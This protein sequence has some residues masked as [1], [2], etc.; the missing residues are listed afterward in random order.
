MARPLARRL[1]RPVGRFAARP[2]GMSPCQLALGQLL[3]VQAARAQDPDQ[4]GQDSDAKEDSIHDA[5]EH[6]RGIT[7]RN[8]ARC[9]TG[10]P[11]ARYIKFD[12]ISI[13]TWHVP[14]HVPWGVPWRVL[15]A[16]RVARPLAH[17]VAHPLARSVARP[18][19]TSYGA[20]PWHVPWHVAWRV[21]WDVSRRV[22]LACP[23]V[24]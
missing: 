16:R 3:C 14:W 9:S 11:S 24:N 23:P 17:P 5:I 1:A 15:L 2:P 21:P 20:T 13:A 7:H 18:L 8:S 10:Q 19:G 22:L 4:F 12:T 6:N